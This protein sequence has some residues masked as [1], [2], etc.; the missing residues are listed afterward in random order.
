MFA[1]CLVIYDAIQYFCAVENECCILLT[2]NLGDYKMGLIPVMTAQDY[3]N[4]ING[5]GANK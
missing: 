2:R 4:Y 3:I 5:S 1:H